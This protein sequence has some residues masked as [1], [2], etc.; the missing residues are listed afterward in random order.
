MKKI[1]FLSIIILGIAYT[2][3]AQNRLYVNASSNGQNT[4]GSWTDA[5]TNLHQAL[6]IAQTG[7]EVWVAEGMYRP[8]TATNRDRSFI[9]KSGVK[10]YG[11]F[12]GTED[13]PTQRNIPGHP[14]VLSGNIGNLADS[15]DNS[16]TILYIAYPDTSTLLDGLNFRHGYAVSD[17]N[18]FNLS[19]VLSGGAVY[20]LAKNGKALPVFAHCTFRDNVA[21]SR[22]GAIFVQGQ[23]STGS[24]PI[25][26]QCVFSNNKS[27]GSGG[28]IFISGGNNLDRGIEFDHCRFESNSAGAYGGAISIENA[29]GNE[30]LNFLSCII[31]KGYAY[32]SGGFMYEL[33]SGSNASKITIDSCEISKNVATNGPSGLIVES[34]GIEFSTILKV[35]N[36][37]IFDNAEITQNPLGPSYGGVIVLGE[38]GLISPT[39]IDT[40]I[41]TGN[42][43]YGNNTGYAVIRYSSNNAWGIVEKNIINNNAGLGI[44]VAGKNIEILKNI[45]FDNA[46]TP[47]SGGVHAYTDSKLQIHDNLLFHNKHLGNASTYYSTN[48]IGAVISTFFGY[49]DTAQIFNNT[50]YENTTWV[51]GNLNTSP[52]QLKLYKNNIFYGNKDFLTGKLTI[53]LSLGQD[54]SYFSLNLMDV[55]CATLP[56]R[57]VCGP[58]NLFNLDPQFRDTANHDY[59]LLPCSPLINAGSNAAA[60]GIPTDLAGNPRIQGGTVDIG[61]YESPAFALAAEPEIH[62]AC[63]GTSNG[64]IS[65]NPVSGCEPYTYTW[66]PAVGNGPELKDLSPGNYQLTITDGSGHQILD[67]LQVASAPVPVLNPVA[68]DVQC[69]TTLGGSIAAGVNNGTAPYHYQWLPTAADTSLLTHLSPGAYALTVVDANNCQDSASASIALLGMISL[70]VQGQ[71]IPCYGQTGWLSALPANGAAPFSWLWQGWP[72]TDSIAQPLSPGIYAVTVSDAYGCTAAFAFPPMTQPDSLWAT[73]GTSPQKDLLSPDGAAVVTTISGGTSPFGF[74]W[75]TGSTQQ[76]I[77]G[78]SAGNYTVTVTDKNGCEAVVAVVVDLMVGTGEAEGLAVMMYPNPAVNWVRVVVPEGMG[79]CSV[80]LSDVSGRVV[81]TAAMT[82][83]G[84]MLDLSGLPVGSY[85]VTVRNGDAALVGRLVKQ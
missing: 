70:K 10:L 23:N 31:T 30:T 53:P 13:S 52:A 28:A 18:F 40:I 51:T 72:G 58:N 26:R 17:T 9:L 8:D 32:I 14:T 47:L 2:S 82:N 81:R 59:S 41:I 64:S 54:S 27:F 80:E 20:I 34:N 66:L 22:G 46:K 56:K 43:L 62:P 76:A 44:A 79:G 49:T 85:L 83:G 39:G 67:T 21:K 77:A 19:P 5:F 48:I 6:A 16:Y 60:A 24:T 50:I 84:C 35:R 74:D 12:A 37:N 38:Y 15:T 73:V 61:A 71:S 7:D 63:V 68:N 65:I 1:F 25:F 55:D 75:N 69:G 4:G 45:C 33:K 78:L 29:F 42:R 3:A 11:S 57:V 36:S